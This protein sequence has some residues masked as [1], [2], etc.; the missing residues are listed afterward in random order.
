M[1]YLYVNKYVAYNSRLLKIVSTSN[2]QCSLF[3]KKSPIIQIFCIPGLL[4]NPI[5]PDKWSF[6]LFY[7][8][9]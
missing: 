6:T 5:N 4:A 8:C 7:F 3:W 9:V 2:C 1:L